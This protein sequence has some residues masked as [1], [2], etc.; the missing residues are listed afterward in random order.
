[1]KI[2]FG[3]KLQSGK[4]TAV[5]YLIERYGGIE[6]SFAAPLYN[7]L[8]YAQET[9]G[10][11]KEKDRKF[12][13]Y[14]GT[15]WARSKDE[16]IWANILIN[17]ITNEDRNVYVSDL[18]FKN[19]FNILKNNGFINILIIR[20]HEFEELHQNHESENSLNDEKNWDFI[21][22]NDGSL[23]EFYNKLDAIIFSVLKK[24][25]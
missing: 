5:K 21:V 7:I 13:Q 3:C 14:I 2:A 18:R 25:I 16:N 4:S 10:F 17:S 12:L 15:E 24:Y 11:K 9:C 19:E 22:H 20:K 1:M 8:Y 6:K 23:E